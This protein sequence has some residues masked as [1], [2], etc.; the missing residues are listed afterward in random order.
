MSTAEKRTGAD[1]D[2]APA[3]AD[4]RFKTA[5]AP[6]TGGG[7]VAAA[8][9]LLGSTAPHTGPTLAY[10]AGFG[11]HVVSE[12]L[13][14]ALPKGQNTPQ[15]CPYGL[16]AE[17][18]SGTAFTAP[19]A[20]N[21]R[22]WLYRTRPAVQHV[23]FEALE[24]TAGDNAAL[25]SDFTVAS[26]DVA[27]HPDQMRWLPCAIPGAGDRTDFVQGLRTVGGA[28]EPTLKSGLA[29]HMYTCNATMADKAFVNSDGDFLIVPQQG[30]LRVTTEFGVLDVDPKEIVVVQRGIHFSVAVAGPS[31]GYV[32]EVYD[33]HFQLPDL[34]PIGANGLA[35]PRDFELPVARYEN[36]EGVDFHVVYKFAGKLFEA[37]QSFSPFNVVAYHGNYVPYKYDL[38]KFCCVNS[39]T[40]DHPAR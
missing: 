16:Y 20:N 3:A 27:V 40:F 5:T 2:G 19:R 35:N 23:P 31:R 21:Q 24:G 32:L 12:A 28:G 14:G 17:Q 30:A 25:V 39:V 13:P 4:K 8:T 38:R 26:K 11:A 6:A 29:I 36:R 18:L 33:R 22:S 34:G 15:R 10:H 9:A 7:I 37:R 1:G